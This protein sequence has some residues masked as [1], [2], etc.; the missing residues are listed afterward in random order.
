MDEKMKALTSKGTWEL[1]SA[2]TEAVIVGCHCVFTLKY[3]PDGS[4][5]KHKVRFVAKGYTQTYDID[6]FETFSPIA[7]MNTIRILFSIVVNFHGYC[8]NWM[9]KMPS[10]MG[11]FRRKYIWSNLQVMLP[12][13][14]LKYVV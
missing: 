9:S 3:R 1:V 2:P 14:R 8:S 4:V 13:G 11:I 10:Y 6:Y 5:D 7:W 12:G